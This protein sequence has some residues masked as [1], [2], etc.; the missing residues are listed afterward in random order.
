MT[1]AATHTDIACRTKV[2]YATHAEAKRAWKWLRKQPGRQHLELY[3]CRHCE[4]FHTGNPPGHQT[5]RRSGHPYSTG[6][7]SAT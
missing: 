2:F 4:G 5:Y 6:R 3:E 1:P 7:S